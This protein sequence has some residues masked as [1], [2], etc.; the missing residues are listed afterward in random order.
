MKRSPAFTAALKI[1]L[2]SAAPG[3]ALFRGLPGWGYAQTGLGLLASS[4]ALGLLT[5]WAP[6]SLRATAIYAASA[7]GVIGA[8]NLRDRRQILPNLRQDYRV[9]LR[10]A[11]EF[12]ALDATAEKNSTKPCR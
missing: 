9:F 4:T 2:A 7:S 8:M 1:Q 6:Q 11:G 3:M 10:Q 12:A 5:I